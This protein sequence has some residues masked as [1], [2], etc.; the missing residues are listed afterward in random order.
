MDRET[1]REK[2]IFALD[3]P[4]AGRALALVDE[5]KGE[6]GWFKIGLEL[7]IAEGP[8][9]VRRISEHSRVFLD[10]KLHDI[11][12][13]VGRATAR[14]AGL[15]AK[16][17]TVHVDAGGA[18]ERAVD[19]AAESGQGMGI[20]GISVLTS[21]S[22]ESLSACG[23]SRSVEHL[24]ASRA[25][26]AARANATGLVCSGLE[27]RIVRQR[28]GNDRLVVTPGIRPAGRDTEDQKRVVTPSQALQFGASHIV[29]GRPIRDAESPR[30]AA[31]TIVD[32]LA[33]I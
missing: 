16:L 26:Q 8:D 32:E 5:L 24:V 23:D 7:F 11:P 12:A 3:V 29:V 4:D 18:F 19:A 10:L 1:A 28:L 20:L 30:K 21:V 33:A 2:L 17:L 25:E 27:A 14:A 13:T 6:V 9:L 22:N 15:G 31:S